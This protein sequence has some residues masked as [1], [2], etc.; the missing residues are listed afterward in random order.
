MRNNQIPKKDKIKLFMNALNTQENQEEVNYVI[1]PLMMLHDSAPELFRGCTMSKGFFHDMFQ[2]AMIVRRR[3]MENELTGVVDPLIDG[4][5]K[6]LGM[7]MNRTVIQSMQEG[8]IQKWTEEEWK[9]EQDSIL[10]NIQ[11]AYM[12]KT[13]EANPPQNEAKSPV[14]GVEVEPVEEKTPKIY[15]SKDEL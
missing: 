7:F 13:E 9:G 4:A 1:H 11:K 8:L 12:A 10:T 2:L 15:M 6:I 5:S 14:L 3:G